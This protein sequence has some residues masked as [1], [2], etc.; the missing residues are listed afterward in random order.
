M[1]SF[2]NVAASP[3]FVQELR[4]VSKATGVS[5]SKIVRDA[6]RAY[7]AAQRKT[8]P[9]Q[10]AVAAKQREAELAIQAEMV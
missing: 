6:C 7:W 2:F 5:M 1:S 10:A 4:A 8:A 3:E 9:M